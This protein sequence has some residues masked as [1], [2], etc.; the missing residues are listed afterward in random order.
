MLCQAFQHCIDSMETLAL[1]SPE[2]QRC[3]TRFELVFLLEMLYALRTEDWTEATRLLFTN[4]RQSMMLDYKW[5]ALEKMVNQLRTGAMRCPNDQ[6]VIHMQCL[7][8]QFL[9]TLHRDMYQR[10]LVPGNVLWH[11]HPRRGAGN[12]QTIN[13]LYL[14]FCL[15]HC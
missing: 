1:E 10:R 3:R 13:R 5:V 11:W 14:C 12:A 15:G 9:L 8:R 2:Y 6:T 4:P 7:A